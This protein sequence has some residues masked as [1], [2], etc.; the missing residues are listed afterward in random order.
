MRHW[1][2][3]AHEGL[4]HRLFLQIIDMVEDSLDSQ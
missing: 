3:T 2:T 4:L 1:V